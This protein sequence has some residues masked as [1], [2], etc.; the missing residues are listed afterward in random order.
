MVQIR[1]YTAS[2]KDGSTVVKATAIVPKLGGRRTLSVKYWHGG[3][4]N[5]NHRLAVIA[6]CEKFLTVEQNDPSKFNGPAYRGTGFVGDY[7]NDYWN[8]T[9]TA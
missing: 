5:D 3:T 9:I 8:V 2:K 1:T 4:R 6:F 7:V